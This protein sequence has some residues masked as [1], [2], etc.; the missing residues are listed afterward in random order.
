MQ[1]ILVVDD[2]L[3]NRTLLQDYLKAMGLPCDLAA[4]GEEC[5]SLLKSREYDLVLLDLMMPRLDGFEVLRQLK[6]SPRD[7]H[8]PTIV[9]SALDSTE[10]LVKSIELGAADFLQKPFLYPVLKARVTAC[11]E[12]KRIIDNEK[13]VRKREREQHELLQDSYRRLALTETARDNL[14]HMIVH[15]LNSPIG[16]VIN[17][18][19]LIQAQAKRERP[20]IAEIVRSAEQ[21]L[22]VAEQMSVLTA[23]ILDV[24][25]FESGKMTVDSQDL[26]LKNYVWQRHEA[27]VPSARAHGISMNLNLPLDQTAR[28]VGDPNLL[29][30][31]IDNLISNAVK[32]ARNY[33]TLSVRNTDI[34]TVLLEVV[35]DGEVI[36]DSAR[37]RVF[38]KYF[39]VDWG[40]G[41]KATRRG[42]GLGLA[43]CKLAVEAM[44]GRIWTAI[45]SDDLTQFCVS[46]PS[47]RHHDSDTR[48]AEAICAG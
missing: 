42:L 46:L 45:G 7:R 23:G 30:R 14:N 24:S 25:K 48:P 27:A 8:V 47:A 34:S 39:Q 16:S 33:V 22:R 40:K 29:D 19:E 21:T 6:Q 15:D 41:I 26:D 28:V 4:D 35:N 10:G 43:F 13:L 1:R 32:H 36:P 9:I 17:Y 44:D 5:L 38:D 3:P 12:H 18:A 11:L 2:E 37:G 20:D 31:V